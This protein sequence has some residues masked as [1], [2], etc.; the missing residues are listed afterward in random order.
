MLRTLTGDWFQRPPAI[1]TKGI[2]SARYGAG[3]S[4][5]SYRVYG[6]GAG[7]APEYH[8][9]NLNYDDWQIGRADYRSDWNVDSQDSLTLQGDNLTK[10]KSDSA[11][12][13]ATYHRQNNEIILRPRMSPAGT[14]WDV[15]GAI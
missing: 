5:F 13:I 3:N 7:R 6:T 11:R 10:E 4:K 1:S 14:C 12:A 9:N 8:L 15:G 2:G